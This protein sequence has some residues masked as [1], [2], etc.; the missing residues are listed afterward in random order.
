VKTFSATIAVSGRSRR[1][2]YDAADEK[3]ALAMAQYLGAALEGEAPT[4]APCV[5]VA[6]DEK[7]ARRLLGGIGRSTLYE[8]IALGRLERVPGV[9]RLLVTTRSIQSWPDSA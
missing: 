3:E 8:H 2:F 1:L 6:V 9:G 5:P 7:E 4:E